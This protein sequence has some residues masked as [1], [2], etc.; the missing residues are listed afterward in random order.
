MAV[1]LTHSL[2]DTTTSGRWTRRGGGRMAQD[3]L[4]ADNCDIFSFLNFFY[5]SL[6]RS[7]KKIFTPKLTPHQS[8]SRHSPRVLEKNLC[9]VQW[10]CSF[11]TALCCVSA[12]FSISLPRAGA[13][14]QVD[15]PGALRCSRTEL[16]QSRDHWLPPIGQSKLH[17]KCLLNSKSPSC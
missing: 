13:A 15:S 12:I 8:E 5:T 16:L 10:R 7:T 9:G 14:G 11:P 2:S 1:L 6:I 4:S 3:D 17:R